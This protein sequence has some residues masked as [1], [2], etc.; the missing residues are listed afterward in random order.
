MP[1]GIERSAATNFRHVLAVRPPTFPSLNPRS[2]ATNGSISPTEG[3]SPSAA[4]ITPSNT[5]SFHQNTLPDRDGG[6]EGDSSFLMH[7]K[8]ASQAFKAS[9]AATPQ[10]NVDDALSDAVNTLQKMLDSN[11]AQSPS[12]PG[13]RD[14]SWDEEDHG[15]SNLPLPPNDLVLKLLKRAKGDAEGQLKI[16]AFWSIYA[17]DRSMALSLGR[18][19]S[20]QDYDIQTDLPAAPEDVDD[21][22]GPMLAN[23]VDVAKLQGDI[24]YQLYSPH[25]QNQLP[26]TKAASA[27]QLAERCSELHRGFQVASST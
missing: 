3:P 1:V 22:A 2:R 8:Q 11:A 14:S 10:L 16:V 6:F 17:M 4:A 25:A 21:P 15:L 24:Y 5:P 9:L 12:A 20:I 19:P 23:W 7:S 27:K 18:A 26:D 13:S